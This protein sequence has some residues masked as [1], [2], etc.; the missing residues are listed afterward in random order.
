M[1]PLYLLFFAL[2]FAPSLFADSS[3]TL[4]QTDSV[5]VTLDDF[6]DYL[7]A[8][9]ITEENKAQALAKPGAVKQIVDTIFLI[10]VMAARAAVNSEVDR[11]QIEA[12][13]VDHRM[14]LLMRAQL[15]LDIEKELAEI[16]WDALA[17]DDYKAFPDRYKTAET[18]RASHI[19]ISSADRTP[20]EVDERLVEVLRALE[21]GDDFE[22]VAR[23]YSDDAGSAAKGGDLGF[24][25]RGRMVPEFEKAAFSLESSGDVSSPVTSQFGVHI[26]Q[27]TARN[28]A[29]VIPFEQA[30][31]Q[32]LAALKKK[33]AAKARDVV[34]ERV[35]E[36]SVRS[37]LGV[38]E[39]LLN[40][41]EQQFAKPIEAP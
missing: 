13:V 37:G 33:Q 7:I 18:V 1:K 23:S 11:A 19:L 12:S 5:I 2:A 28:P 4:Y 32:I 14:R 15:D 30:K 35:K 6:N 10:K 36:E 29:G 31:P 17:L 3:P 26:I 40:Q 9:D 41:L 22:S 34:L 20:E 39:E 27:L 25:A 16:D 21:S 8:R 38:N 24:F